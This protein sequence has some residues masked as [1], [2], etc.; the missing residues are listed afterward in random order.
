MLLE[1][2]KPN[3]AN[4]IWSAVPSTAYPDLN[5]SMKYVLD[6]GALVQRIPWQV[7]DTY[8]K[9]PQSYINYVT[10]HYGQAV[11]IFDGYAAGPSTKD[12]T[13]HCRGGGREGRK[14]FNKDMTL[15]LKRKD[16][17]SNKN[18]QSYIGLLGERL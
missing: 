12:C 16:V 15:Q 10:K 17:L 6:G 1:A 7:G 11:V 13:H 2:D 8:D 9:I 14:V 4:K 3:L 18:K 5:D